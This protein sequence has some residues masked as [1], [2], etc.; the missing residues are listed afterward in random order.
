MTEDLTDKQLK[1][2]ERI[3]NVAGDF[4]TAAEVKRAAVS[5]G[6]RTLHDRYG[7]KPLTVDEV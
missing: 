5:I 4:S 3:K 6:I 2:I 1:E 7:M